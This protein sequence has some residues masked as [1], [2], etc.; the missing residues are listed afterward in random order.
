MKTKLN[1]YEVITGDNEIVISTGSGSLRYMVPSRKP[2]FST[3][4]TTNLE[5]T[6]YKL[7]VKTWEELWSDPD[8]TKVTYTEP[9]FY[10]KGFEGKNAL[11]RAL[12]YQNDI[13]NILKLVHNS[14]V[15]SLFNI[16]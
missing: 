11:K 2:K 9:K 6:Y 16:L 4:L 8:A 14:R 13:S 10:Y 5:R 12:D 7:Q 1:K 15:P 3:K